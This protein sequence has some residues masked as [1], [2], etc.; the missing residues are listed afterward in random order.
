MSMCYYYVGYIYSTLL[1]IGKNPPFITR[2]ILLSFILINIVKSIINLWK[3]QNVH[4]IVTFSN[5]L[6]T[7]IWMY[8]ECNSNVKMG[9]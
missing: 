9:D 5:Y 2:Y 8:F 6:Y 3:G 7:S 1:E 4:A